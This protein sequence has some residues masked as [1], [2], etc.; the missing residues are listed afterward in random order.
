[1]LYPFAIAALTVAIVARSKRVRYPRRLAKFAALMGCLAP[2][3][4]FTNYGL[5]KIP[6]VTIV[7]SVVFV[8]GVAATGGLI[9]AIADLLVPLHKKTDGTAPENSVHQE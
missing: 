3:W 7:G 2:I 6:S 1:V 8:S 4:L 5:G 9:G